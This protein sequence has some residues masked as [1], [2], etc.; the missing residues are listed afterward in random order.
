MDRLRRTVTGLSLLVLIE[1]VL[2]GFVTFDDPTNAGFSLQSL[3]ISY[4]AVLPLIHRVFAVVLILSWI[5]G[6]FYLKGTR[7]FRMS[8]ITIGLMFIQAIIGA[9][10]PAT[11][12][13]PSVNPY[14]I[15]AHFSFSGFILI[16]AGFTAYFG[17][18]AGSAAAGRVRKP[19]GM[20]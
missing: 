3:S 18:A 4:P 12:S 11:L 7:A 8:H 20:L 10:I 2:G 16:G 17:W 15:I 5:L 19:Q 9:M 6:S 13:D 1:Y 14:I